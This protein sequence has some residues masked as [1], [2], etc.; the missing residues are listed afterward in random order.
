MTGKL[1]KYEIKSSMKLMAA[2]WAALMAASLLFS[3]SGN[4]LSDTVGNL[5][6]G[7]DNFVGFV[8]VLTGFMYGLILIALVVATIIIVVMRF[9]KGLLCDEGYLMHTLPVKPWQLIMSKGIVATLVVLISIAI[10]CLS[11]MIIIGTSSFSI[12]PDLFAEIKFMWD[13]D[14]RYVLILAEFLILVVFSLIKSIYQIYASLAIGQL[15]GKYR[16]ILSL[17]AYIGISVIV[18]TLFILFVTVGISIIETHNVSSWIASME[19]NANDMFLLGQIG[20]GGIFGFTAL[21]LIAFHVITERI[22]S[23]KLNLQ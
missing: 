7:A 23:L 5:S 8:E 19:G 21:Q 10:I 22:L 9:Y 14:P 15:A 3:L 1:V 17:A 13:E 20:I 6:S 12:I 2:V 18:T 4:V 16:I 11:V